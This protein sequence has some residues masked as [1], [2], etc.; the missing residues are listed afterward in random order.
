LFVCLFVVR[1]FVYLFVRLFVGVLL[2]G[3]ALV[4]F[5]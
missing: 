4:L 1:S 3:I 5:V 2:C